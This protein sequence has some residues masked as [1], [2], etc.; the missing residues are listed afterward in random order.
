MFSTTNPRHRVVFGSVLH[1]KASQRVEAG[2]CAR[3][4]RASVEQVVDNLDGLVELFVGAD[5]AERKPTDQ[6]KVTSSGTRRG[7]RLR[8]GGHPSLSL[9]LVAFFGRFGGDGFPFHWPRSYYG[10]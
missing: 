3:R 2:V 7:P 6:L 5:R 1:D 8:L 9:R 4:A 10:C